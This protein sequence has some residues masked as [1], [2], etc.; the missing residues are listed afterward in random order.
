M[1]YGTVTQQALSGMYQG[2]NFALNR[3]SNYTEFTT[4]FD[5]YRICAVEVDFKPMYNMQ[6]ISAIN[7]VITLF[8]YT[9]IDYDD[10]AAPTSISQLEEYDSCVVTNF[11]QSCKRIIRPK[12]ATAVYDGTANWAYASTRQP[13]VDCGNAAVQWF[14]LKLAIEAGA[15]GQTNLQTWQISVK[16]YIE[17]RNVR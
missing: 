6:V 11:N 10:N 3:V 8:L 15:S 1:L 13:W 7:N 12:L 4:L 17:L 14:G 2:M 9:V 5:E 16:Y